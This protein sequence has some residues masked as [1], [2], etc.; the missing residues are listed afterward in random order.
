MSLFWRYFTDTL[1]WRWIQTAGP[2]AALVK[3][4]A[5]VMD[6]VREDVLWLRR[7]AFPDT[8]EDQ[9]LAIHGDARGVCQRENETIELYRTRVIKAY[10][11][12]LLGGK[13]LGLPRV[14]EYYGYPDTRIHNMRDDDLDRW[15]E[16]KVKFPKTDIKVLE[17]TDFPA[18]FDTVEDQ[19]PARSKLAALSF[20]REKQGGLTY[21]CAV[22]HSKKITVYPFSSYSAKSAQRYV[23][24]AL[25]IT[26]KLRIGHH[27]VTVGIKEP[28]QIYFGST[29]RITKRIRIGANHV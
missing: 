12:Q 24:T 25:R 6:D 11:W 28:S 29:I 17:E 14:L 3:G 19:K 27:I 15:A 2:L 10:A 9:F 26:K 13:N 8:C 23:G 22:R 5:R 18:I 20:E 21:A 16:F 1:R 4:G 7:Q